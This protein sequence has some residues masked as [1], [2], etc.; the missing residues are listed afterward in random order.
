MCWAM[1]YPSG[2]GR[3]VELGFFYGRGWGGVG[4]GAPMKFFGGIK[5]PEP[6]MNQT[7]SLAL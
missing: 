7:L 2:G 6:R 4:L 5:D 1:R 3:G